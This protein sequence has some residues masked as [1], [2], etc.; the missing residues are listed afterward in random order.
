MTKMSYVLSKS[1]W[2]IEKKR[3][4][5]QTNLVGEITV[6]NLETTK[7]KTKQSELELIQV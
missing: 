1:E 7:E 4:M 6:L 2:D 3:E 5:M